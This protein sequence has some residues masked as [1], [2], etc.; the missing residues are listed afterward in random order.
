MTDREALYRAILEH[1]DDDTPRLIYADVL[2]DE[3]HGKLAAF[4]RAQVELARV[5]DWDPLAVRHRYHEREP[6]ADARLWV[7]DLPLPDG[8]QWSRDPFRRG[9]PAAVEVKDGAA[10]LA[11]ADGLFAQYP[12]ESVE[13]AALRLAEARRLGES[14]WLNRVTRLG[15]PAGLSGQVAQRLLNSPNL[16]RLTEVTVGGQMTVASAARALVR[17]RAFGRLTGLSWRDD[18]RSGGAVVAELT[19]LTD[20]PRLKRLDLSGN[21]ITAGALA[22]LVAAPALA[23]VEDLDLSDNNLGPEGVRA[24]AA[25]R[26]PHLHSLHLLRTR[27]ETEGV[28]ALVGADFFPELRSL[29]LGGNNLGPAAGRLLADGPGENLRVLDLRENK[30]ADRGAAALAASPHLRNLVLLDLAENQIGED[31]AGAVAHPPHP[32][33]LDGLIYLNLYGNPFSPP[34]AARLRERFGDRV[35]L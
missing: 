22:S 9:L 16:T 10:F 18:Q 35:F 4:V 7:L 5:P 8:V 27:P 24:L 2:E 3:G 31:G 20:P 1:P 15:F 12:V 17:S 32:G 14:R 19:R 28:R 11:H 26:L 29:S 25:A 23:G 33:L 34:A 30:L 13:F 6:A 21:R